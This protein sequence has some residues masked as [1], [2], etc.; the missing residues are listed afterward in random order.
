MVTCRFLAQERDIAGG[1]GALSWCTM[2]GKLLLL[3]ELGW[4]HPVPRA[5]PAEGPALPHTHPWHPSGDL[6]RSEC[7]R[8]RGAVERGLDELEVGCV[9]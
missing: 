3:V 5:R 2:R 7:G 4:Q 6:A 1:E 9:E 8:P